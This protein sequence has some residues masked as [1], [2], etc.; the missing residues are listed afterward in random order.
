MGVHN[1]ERLADLAVVRCRELE[2]GEIFATKAAICFSPLHAICVLAKVGDWQFYKLASSYVLHTW[3][4]LCLE[5]LPS[6][7]LLQLVLLWKPFPPHPG[8]GGLLAYVPQQV[9]VCLS[10]TIISYAHLL[11]QPF[12]PAYVVSAMDTC[13]TSTR[14]RSY[15][16]QKF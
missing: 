9:T 13:R 10:N 5:S 2:G 8:W 3:H 12:P 6:S 4:S 16:V 7:C 15:Y 14:L 11:F 1:S